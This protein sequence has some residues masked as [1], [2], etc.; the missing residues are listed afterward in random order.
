MAA[1]N[2]QGRRPALNRTSVDLTVLFEFREVVDEGRVNHTV[3]GD[4][5]PSQALQVFDITSVHL[6]TSC[7]QKLGPSF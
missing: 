4:H 7:D 1:Q 5:S 2:R 3:S 6:G